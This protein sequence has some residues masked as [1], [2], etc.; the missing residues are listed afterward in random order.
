[1]GCLSWE[2]LQVAPKLRIAMSEILTDSLLNK[3]TA[4]TQK[5]LNLL[6]PVIPSGKGIWELCVEATGSFVLLPMRVVCKRLY[7]YTEIL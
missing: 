5:Q 6:V 3:P 4:C 1:M 7:V 2:A